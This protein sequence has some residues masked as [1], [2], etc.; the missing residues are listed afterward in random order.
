MSILNLDVY[1]QPSVRLTVRSDPTMQMILRSDGSISKLV[2]G[3]G[4]NTGST[5]QPLPANTN[6][7][8]ANG[9]VVTGQVLT[10]T[11]GTWTNAASLAYQWFRNGT[12]IS[13]ETSVT[14]TVIQADILQLIQVRE[15]A[16]N[17]TGSVA[18]DSNNAL[19][20]FDA[21]ASD[22][23]HIDIYA[24]EASALSTAAS[25]PLG[26][27]VTGQA[28]QRWGG[29]I[30][31]LTGPV[32]S[33]AVLTSRPSFTTVAGASSVRFDG[34][35]DRLIHDGVGLASRLA[36]NWSCEISSTYLKSSTSQP[37]WGTALTSNSTP[38]QRV[39]M[40][41]A[42]A[43]NTVRN[44]I[45]DDNSATSA[46]I[47]TST[48]TPNSGVPWSFRQS[49]RRTPTDQSITELQPNSG[50][51]TASVGPVATQDRIAFG[52]FAT[53]TSV[54]GF[55]FVAIHAMAFWDT[56]TPTALSVEASR[57]LFTHWNM[58]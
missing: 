27:I 50:T 43:A 33:E 18:I 38:F 7:V 8:T 14:Y 29:M 45:R 12:P 21:F 11:A 34:N 37:I 10:L 55:C 31:G 41:N 46:S 28:V 6:P 44:T 23:A 3:T 57:C 22:P 30:Y 1:Y 2:D 47:M 5:P 39:A 51:S 40:A 15:T 54:A 16:T 32:V 35:N 56:G 4:L 24:A 52:A 26:G 25:G 48:R 58:P 49:H 9:Y 19:N 13:G 42:A 36:V 53:P 20:A 17:P